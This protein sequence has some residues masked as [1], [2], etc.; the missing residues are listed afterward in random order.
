MSMPNPTP[1]LRNVSRGYE[2]YSGAASSESHYHDPGPPVTQADP[3]D[4][5]DDGLGAIGMAATSPILDGPDSGHQM[6]HAGGSSG[7]PD[8][9]QYP[10][11]QQP[12]FHIPTPQHL[13]T[14]S[15]SAQNLFRSPSS[16]ISNVGGQRQGRHIGGGYDYDGEDEEDPG[17]RPPS[18]GAVAGPGGYQ[19]PTNEKRGYR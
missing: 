4:G 2:P 11:Q 18:Y 14:S 16:P 15:N 5:Y 3:Y 13:V 6:N 9:R 10:T 12:Q 1:K 17:I 7:Y 8:R 19:A